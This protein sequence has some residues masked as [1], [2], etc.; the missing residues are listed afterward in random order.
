MVKLMEKNR[1]VERDPLSILIL[2]LD[3]SLRQPDQRNWM[4][5]KVVQVELRRSNSILEDPRNGPPSRPRLA[6]TSIFS[7]FFGMFAPICLSAHATRGSAQVL[8]FNIASI[9][10]GNP[11][12]VGWDIAIGQ[13]KILTGFVRS[14]AL[15]SQFKIPKHPMGKAKRRS[16]E[17]QTQ[18]IRRRQGLCSDAISSDACCVTCWENAASL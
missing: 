14:G 12:V 9:F 1:H 17:R 11:R 6:Q 3:Q 18:I 16:W 4:Q 5:K 15:P 13:G 2:I 8:R 7:L 10:A